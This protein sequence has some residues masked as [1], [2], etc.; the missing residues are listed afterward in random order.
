MWRDVK[1]KS[2]VGNVYRPRR[3]VLVRHGQS[4][5]NVDRNITMHV[6]DHAL[7]ITELGRSQA[8]DA[9]RSLRQIICDESVMFM[10]SPY[11]RTRET[12]HGVAQAFRGKELKV[13]EDVQLREQDFGNFDKLNMKELHKEKNVFGQ[14]YYRF[15]EGESMA[16]VYDRASHFLESLYRRWE[17]TRELNTVIISHGL[18]ILIFVMRLFRYSV[19]ELYTITGLKNGEMVVIERPGDSMF[20]KISYTIVPGEDPVPWDKRPRN[21]KP[22]VEQKIWMG[23]IRAPPLSSKPM[24][25]RQDADS[26][27]SATHDS[28]T[29]V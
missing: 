6:P 4:E 19:E 2:E 27:P 10:M 9:G 8:I 14:F 24:F 5:G 22:S 26:A 16:D 13:R 17:F 21:E 18:F 25:K 20:F 15:P 28:A 12:F 11:I 1:P 29:V 3:L 7:H 23:D